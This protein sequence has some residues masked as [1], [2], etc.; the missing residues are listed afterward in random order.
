MFK[1]GVITISVI[2]NLVIRA[3]ADFSQMRREMQRAQSDLKDFGSKMK[4]SLGGI[5]AALAGIGLGIGLKSAVED[6]IKFEALMGTL[7]QT[8]GKSMSDFVKWQNTVGDA[9]GFS[10]LQVAEMGNNYSLRLKSIAKDEQDLL[11]KTTDLIKAAAIIRSKTG[12]SSIEISDRMRSAM[13]Q[14][15]DG[16]DELGINVR[17]AAIQQS[18]AYKQLA[19]NAPWEELSEQ[20]KKTILYHHILDSTT[21]NF[22]TEIAQNTALLKGGF[23]S[24]LGDARLALGQAFLPI[25]N[26]ALPLLTKMARAAEVA[27]QNVSAFMRTL[28]PKANIKAGNAQTAAI[29]SQSGAVDGLGDSLDS[30]GK[31]AKKAANSLA[32][33]D[34]INQL[35]SGSKDDDEDSSAATSGIGLGTGADG[36]DEA[37][38]AVSSKVR[39]MADKVKAAF[40]E[41][42]AFIVQH[43]EIIISALYGIA[44]AFATLAVIKSVSFL[45][46]GIGAAIGLI[47]SPIGLL[48]IAIASLVG[49]FTY[50]YRNNEG[51]R[52]KVNAIWEEIK[53]SLSA[54]WDW[55]VTA[56][57]ATWKGLEQ[58]WATNGDAIIAT[59]KATW[60]GIKTFLTSTFNFINT[61]SLAIW[62]GMQAFWQRWGDDI[63]R[64]FTS[65]WKTISAL[66]VD[67]SNFIVEKLKVLAA[68]WNEYW[69][70][71]AKALIN[72]WKVIWYFLEPFVGAIIKGLLMAW[73]TFATLLTA[74]WADIKQIISG[75][76]DV[77]MGIVKIF[78]G[79]FTLDWKTLWDGIKQVTKGATD[80]VQ[81]VI[82]L[83]FDT[84]GGIVMT[85]ASFIYGAYIGMMETL[86]DNSKSMWEGISSVIGNVWDGI[87]NNI[88][89]SINAITGMINGFI[90][91]FNGIKI[92]VPGVNIPLVGMVGGFEIGMPQIPRIPML[93]NGGITDVNN[94]FLAMVGDNKT[95]REVVAP[96]G[97]LTD[98]ISSAVGSAV[99]MANQFNNSQ[100]NGGRNGGDIVLQIDGTTIARI[101][102]TYMAK[103]SSRIGG[104]MITAT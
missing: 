29:D 25:L 56:A 74:L 22:G 12:L 59:F 20:M 16:A 60:E 6:A 54:A 46:Q 85:A 88:K 27:F 30:T 83:V 80:A 87:K 65:I 86:R 35:G 44:A 55:I 62:G 50:F 72:A 94:P 71:I 18:K 89:N 104:S 45:L 10:K 58:F 43:K 32:G 8:L 96:L 57:R 31:K 79:V 1:K 34:E 21:A 26:I 82:S 91:K 69:P 17:V 11:K 14:E 103:E 5:A 15:A 81:G 48:V 33:F 70:D 19:D 36:I 42:S 64:I 101:L 92:N 98:M 38:G 37:T 47:L 99:M 28:F 2:R 3:G 4:S 75:V 84:I 7:S 52:D 90:D 39:E 67:I 40:G 97:D 24:A 102:N 78:I 73:E 53:V 49:A 41:M 63:T 51:F 68:F 61:I 76:L 13:N 9:M 93:A 100:N 23:V 95:Q 77:I 66:V